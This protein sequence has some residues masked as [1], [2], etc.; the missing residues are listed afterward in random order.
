MV[1]TSAISSRDQSV[2]AIWKES[3]PGIF[4]GYALIAVEFWKGDILKADIEELLRVEASDIY[5]RRLNAKEV[6]TTP[7]DGE[8]VLL[9]ADGSAT[10]SGRD[11]EFQEPT[12][13]REPTVRSDNFSGK[14]Q[15]DREEFQLEET[16]DDAETQ[17]DFWSIDEFCALSQQSGSCGNSS[18]HNTRRI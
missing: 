8:F 15:G 18:K 17:K 9:V 7:K 16:N 1:A 13:R 10:L 3:F 4:F 11:Y 6:L 14:S 2:P 5:P 12:L